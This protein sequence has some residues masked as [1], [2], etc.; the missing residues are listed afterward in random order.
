MK[1]YSNKIVD[2]SQYSELLQSIRTTQK[3]TKQAKTIAFI[4]LA[5][6]VVDLLWM[7]GTTFCPYVQTLIK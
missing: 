7:L 5:L 6:S 3:T 1:S 4:A 2:D